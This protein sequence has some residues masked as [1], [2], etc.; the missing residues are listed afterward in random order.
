MLGAGNA[1]PKK[2]VLLVLGLGLVTVG[3]QVKEKSVLFKEHSF[4]KFWLKGPKH[5]ST[6]GGK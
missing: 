3:E 6:G 2:P 4:Q 1:D 5:G